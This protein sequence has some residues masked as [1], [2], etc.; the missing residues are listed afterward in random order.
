MT[1]ELFTDSSGYYCGFGEILVGFEFSSSRDGDR[2]CAVSSAA[3][4]L[5]ILRQFLML[6]RS[7]CKIPVSGSHVLELKHLVLV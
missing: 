7:S 1:Y 2:L 5:W 4:L 3:I 6:P